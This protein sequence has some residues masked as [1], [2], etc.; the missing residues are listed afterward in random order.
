MFFI[1][2]IELYLI[3]FLQQIYIIRTKKPEK[4]HSNFISK[5]ATINNLGYINYIRVVHNWGTNAIC[6]FN[7]IH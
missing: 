2:G 1:P 3:F 6:F 4:A 7:L 5:R